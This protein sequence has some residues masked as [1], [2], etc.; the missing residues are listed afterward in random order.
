MRINSSKSIETDG[1][2]LLKRLDTKYFLLTLG[3][4]GM[5]IFEKKYLQISTIAK[6]VLDVSGA[7]DTV[8]ATITLALQT[9]CYIQE[10][11]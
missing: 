6:N 8:I 11:V 4:E 2:Q 10:S 9:G 5:A 7:G 1:S 3:Q